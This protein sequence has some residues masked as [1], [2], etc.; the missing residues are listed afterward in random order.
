MRALT[1]SGVKKL[2]TEAL[3][4][5]EPRFI[6]EKSGTMISGSIIS[7]SFRGKKDLARLDMIHDA[8]SAA[9]GPDARKWVG[10]LLAYTPDEWEMPLEGYVK[11]KK[12]KAS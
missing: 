5:Q 10:M 9:L 1:V 8:L 12:A 4:L 6:L 2:L 7:K 11:P 3:K